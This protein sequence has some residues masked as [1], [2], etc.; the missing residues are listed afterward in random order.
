M[1]VLHL[2][3]FLSSFSR[4]DCHESFESTQNHVPVPYDTNSIARSPI[5]PFLASSLFSLCLR[6]LSQNP[7]SSYWNGHYCLMRTCTI[8]FCHLWIWENLRE[9]VTPGSL[10]G[11]R[12]GRRD[13]WASTV[14]CEVRAE[15]EETVQ[16]CDGLL[17]SLKCMHVLQ[18]WPALLQ[19]N[20]HN[21]RT[22]FSGHSLL[23][24]DQNYNLGVQLF[25]L[26]AFIGLFKFG[27]FLDDRDRFL[28]HLAICV[29]RCIAPCQSFHLEPQ[30]NAPSSW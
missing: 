17:A 9:W 20:L 10:W 1:L 7:G 23:W 21:K 2:I 6:I 3:G 22:I 12:W 30:F 19:W 16:S 27:M 11:P 18:A 4:A 13:G 14:L 24:S 28:V 25:Y 26:P 15:A 29:H 8:E 5:I